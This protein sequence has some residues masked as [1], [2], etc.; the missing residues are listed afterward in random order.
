M[1]TVHYEVVQHDGGWAYK[2]GDVRSERYANHDEARAAAERAA[3]D[4]RRP[5]QPRISSIRT[6]Q[7]SGTRKSRKGKTD[8]KR[9]SPVE[10]L[11]AFLIARAQGMKP[12]IR[13]MDAG[14]RLGNGELCF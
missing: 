11:E 8:Q 1:N 13:L 6:R 4:Q 10:Q 7:V 2:V 12:F 3:A 5:A 9:M 14:L